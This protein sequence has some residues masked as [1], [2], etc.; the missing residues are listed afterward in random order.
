MSDTAGREGIFAINVRMFQDIDLKEL[1]F[2]YVDGRARGMEYKVPEIPDTSMVLSETAEL[3]RYSANCHC[4]TV[5]YT[6]LI[7]SLEHLKV[8][9]CDCSICT[10]N[11]YLLVFPDRKEVVFYT[12]YDHLHSYA[13]GEKRMS[14]QFCPT[15]G[16]SVMIDFHGGP[17]AVE[18]GDR[19]G[20]N[21]R[22]VQDINLDTLKLNE[23]IKMKNVGPEYKQWK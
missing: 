8:V 3:T 2:K 16:S 17:S 11:G 15:C 22:M 18:G 23:D 14:H 9:D 7:P 19:L 1:K 13:F 5:T 6:F 10:R 21:V 20:L 4:G 12:G